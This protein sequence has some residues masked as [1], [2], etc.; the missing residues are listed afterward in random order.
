MGRD[1]ENSDIASGLRTRLREE[2]EYR[3]KPMA[4]VGGRPLL[5][6]IMQIHSHLGFKSFVS[7]FWLLKRLF[8]TIS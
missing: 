7:C 1:H 5:W 4:Q 2:T 3:L 8:A 6:I